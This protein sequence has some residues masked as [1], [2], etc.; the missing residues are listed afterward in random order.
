[1]VLPLEFDV[2]VLVKSLPA[3]AIGIDLSTE[4]ITRSVDVHP[5]SGLVTVSV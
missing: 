4:I 3:S 5:V 1:M 2:H